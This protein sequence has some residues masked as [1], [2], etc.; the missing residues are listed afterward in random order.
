M[1]SFF[2]FDIK[3]DVKKLRGKVSYEGKRAMDRMMLHK[4]KQG[5]AINI[6]IDDSVLEGNVVKVKELGVDDE[7]FSR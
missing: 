2:F 7:F 4:R 3:D 6:G 5:Y 1:I